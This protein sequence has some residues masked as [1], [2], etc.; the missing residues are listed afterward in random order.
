MN[1]GENLKNIRKEHNL[2]QEQIAEKLGVSRQSVSKWESNQAYPEMD[3]MI[4]ICQLFNLNIDDLLNQDI[5]EIKNN[6]QTKSNINKFIDDFLDYI[7]KTI[8][9]FSSMKFMQKI[10]C[11]FEQALIIGIIAI[12]LFILG[13]M[14]SSIIFRLFLFLPNEIYYALYHIFGGLYMIFSLILGI[15][16]VLHIFKVR[17]LDY[18]IIVK[19]DA[20]DINK[21]ENKFTEE[22]TN[23]EN[24]F[25]KEKNKI[26]LAKKQEKIII[27]DPKHTGYKFISGLLNFLLFIMKII[28]TL[29]ASAFCF[30]FIS[31]IICLIISFLFIKTGI[32]FIGLLL[33]IISLLIINFI[34]L[35]IC[36]NFIV[37]K[38]N[39]KSIFATM[40]IISLILLGSGIGFG[41]IGITNFEVIN[42]IKDSNSYH[43]ITEYMEMKDDLLF[44][45]Y[46]EG[47]NYVESNNENLKIVIDKSKFY[48][49]YLNNYHNNEYHF[50][51]YF[52]FNNLIKNIKQQIKDI[53]NRKII[54]YSDI[55]VTIYTTKENIEIL[56][57][58]MIN[59][60]NKQEEIEH[61]NIINDYELRI[62]KY[63]E[64]IYDLQNRLCTLDPINCHY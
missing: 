39:K 17:Y 54:D 55:T 22:K 38:K 27:R 7:T 5:K 14:A 64:E 42:D 48:T 23:N 44:F 53:N 34:I 28:T 36:Y 18:Y 24:D 35:N 26:F 56:K 60:Q 63:Q 6:K 46:Y 1:L 32:L 43:Q 47:I 9:M 21:K 13:N 15:I 10:K 3:K 19:D 45:E 20:I 25:N 31:L 40:F 37:S 49:V 52:S 57:N 30:T 8:D 29:I 50:N 62:R 2:S 51:H 41:M 16:L 12:I 59:Y 61:Q 58:N 33:G 11:L 4:Q